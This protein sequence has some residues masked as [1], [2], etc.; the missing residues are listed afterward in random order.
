[1][2]LPST[3]TLA[4]DRVRGTAL[5]VASVSFALFDDDESDETGVRGR[6][7]VVDV[8]RL[9]ISWTFRRGEDTGE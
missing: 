6:R 4:F 2:T 7:D 3:L 5:G 1:M 8:L 9:V